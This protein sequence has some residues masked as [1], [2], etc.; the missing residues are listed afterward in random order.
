[1]YNLAEVQEADEYIQDELILAGISLVRGEKTKSKV[2]Y[3]ITGKLG[4]WTFEREGPYWEAHAITRKGL[5]LEIAVQ[6]HEQ[7]YP[8]L[9]KDGAQIYG[10]FI[11]VAGYCTCLHPRELIRTTVYINRDTIDSYHID[12]QLGLNELA[13]V[14][15]ECSKNNF[16]I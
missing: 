4:C 6:M 2:P 8:V 7:I 10:T 13:R 5:P 9:G 14:I 1:M 16:I 12:S 3:T 15:R 11:R